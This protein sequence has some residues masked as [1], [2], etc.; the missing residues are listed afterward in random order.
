MEGLVTWCNEN[1]LSV[2]IGN[3]KELII[4][5]RKKGCEHSPIYKNGTEGETVEKVKFLRVTITD[6][7]VLEFS[8]RCDSQEGT[9]MPILPQERSLTNF[10]RCTFESIPS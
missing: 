9:T 2:N 5:F 4:D 1:N 8:C 10:Y 6:K 3:T 7:T